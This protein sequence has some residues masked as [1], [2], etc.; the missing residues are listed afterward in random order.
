M[1]RR[2]SRQKAHQLAATY[3]DAIRY[4]FQQGFSANKAADIVASPAANIEYSETDIREVINLLRKKM[5]Y[6]YSTD[7]DHSEDVFDIDLIHALL[8]SLEYYYKT[9]DYG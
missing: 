7:Y 2:N 6:Y 5:E 4:I 8:R 9:G 3:I 1:R